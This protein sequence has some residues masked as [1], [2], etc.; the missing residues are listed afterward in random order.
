MRRRHPVQK[1]K[2]KHKR[3]V[4][5]ATIQLSEAAPN[6]HIAEITNPLEA[7]VAADK[8]QTQVPI[9]EVTVDMSSGDPV[10]SK[11]VL[12][13]EMSRVIQQAAAVNNIQMTSIV[14]QEQVSQLMQDGSITTIT[15]SPHQAEQETNIQMAPVVS[16]QEQ[17][18]DQGS[19]TQLIQL[20][21]QE[22]VQQ[23]VAQNGATIV[24]ITSDQQMSA[25]EQVSQMAAGRDTD[26]T[27]IMTIPSDHHNTLTGSDESDEQQQTSN[28]QLMEVVSSEQMSQMV[29]NDNDIATM[30]CATGEQQVLTTTVIDEE[31]I[32]VSQDQV[33]AH[34]MVAGGQG[35]VITTIGTLAG[36]DGD[37]SQPGDEGLSA[38]M[39]SG[40]IGAGDSVVGDRDSVSIEEGVMVEEGV[41]HIHEEGMTIG[42][43]EEL[44]Q[45]EPAQEEVA[46][47]MDSENGGWRICQ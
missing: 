12:P 37:S 4:D 15:T 9:N 35:D 23:M 39:D 33:A 30:S 44:L 7:T 11:L 2:I 28:V 46:M 32:V 14:S 8:V 41:I 24:N 45:E 26:A 36:D 19:S 38:Q 6:Q 29:N 5:G 10:T 22:Q 43:D 27:T 34:Q 47:E 31:T 20:L 40:G 42:D 13:I 18:S 21:T 16:M 25:E 17:V 3:G 1:V